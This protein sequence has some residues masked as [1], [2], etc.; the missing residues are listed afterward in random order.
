MTIRKKLRTDEL[1]QSFLGLLIDHQTSNKLKC[2]I[3]FLRTSEPKASYSPKGR[4][5]R[6]KK[7]AETAASHLVRYRGHSIAGNTS[8][9][10][11]RT[12]QPRNEFSMEKMFQDRDKKRLQWEP[13]RNSQNS[14]EVL[15]ML[16]WWFG[17]TM[18]LHLASGDTWEPFIFSRLYDPTW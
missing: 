14:Q 9:F 11:S 2:N 17:M 4:V 5:S 16:P 8:C 7:L 1:F 6:Q 15:L 12:H 18:E 10:T 13:D 3:C